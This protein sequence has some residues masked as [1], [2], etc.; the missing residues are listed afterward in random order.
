ML[1]R[2]EITLPDL[3]CELQSANNSTPGWRGRLDVQVLAFFFPAFLRIL[4]GPCVI[5]ANADHLHLVPDEAKSLWVLASL[6][7]A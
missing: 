7:E 1:G 5:I 2:P 4:C 6:R 3:S